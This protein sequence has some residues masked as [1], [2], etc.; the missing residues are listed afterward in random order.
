MDAVKGAV[1]RMRFDHIGIFVK[2]LVEGRRLLEA[3][4]G[5]ERWTEVFEDPGIGVYVQFGLGTDGPCYELV[6]PR[7][8]NSPVDGALR[9]GKNILNHVAYLTGDL[10]GD[11]ERLRAL[12][13]VAVSAAQPAV[14]YGGQRVQFWLTPLRMIVELV[15]ALEHEHGYRTAVPQGEGMETPF[16]N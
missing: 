10:D 14:A 4:F 11:G 9:T 13:G 5:I 3:M 16:P 8:Q 7:G 2:E 6:A 1:G 15:E 12:G